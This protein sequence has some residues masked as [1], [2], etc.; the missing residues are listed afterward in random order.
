[1]KFSGEIL[2]FKLSLREHITV[3]RSRSI[4]MALTVKRKNRKK[5]R[6]YF[7]NANELDE[8]Y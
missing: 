3:A 4:L 5:F 8:S 6:I 2:L 7:T 1:M